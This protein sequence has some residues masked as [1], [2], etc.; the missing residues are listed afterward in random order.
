MI[1]K[2]LLLINAVRYN[3]AVFSTVTA[4][5]YVIF[6]ARPDMIT[7]D[8]NVSPLGI[9]GAKLKPRKT[10]SYNM[11][12]LATEMMIKAGNGSLTRLSASECL[13][14]YAI[15]FQTDYRHVI[16]VTNDTGKLAGPRIY[17]NFAS[18]IDPGSAQCIADPFDWVCGQDAAHGCMSRGATVCAAKHKSIKANEWEPLGQRVD[19]C[20]A[21]KL[22]GNC[23]VQFS[24]TIAWVV[25]AFNTSKALV[26]VG[27]FFL[28][29]DDPMT[30]MGD[31]VASYLRVADETTTGLCLMSR[32]RLSLWRTPP[33]IPQPYKT[34]A[35]RNS[36][37]WFQ[38]VSGSRWR[39]CMFL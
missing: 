5:E 13:S 15:T 21:E 30:T 31:A 11:T 4:H 37:R 16:L 14:A 34:G 1:Y 19:H 36:R 24:T 35:Y 17:N 6:S 12:S 9:S 8:P 39:F 2:Y 20:L 22:P 23:K 38:V 26:L 25:I 28:L 3:S 27:I 18:A 29:R 7:A 33:A 10:G 32:D